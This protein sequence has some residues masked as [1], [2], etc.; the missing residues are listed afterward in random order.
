M[1]PTELLLSKL[2]DA[3]QN[4]NGWIAK[5]PA[6]DDRSPSLSISEGDDGRA[7]VKC[8]AG[9]STDRVVEEMGLKMSDLMSSKTTENEN[10]PKTKSGSS[11]P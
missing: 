7:L 8:H 9:C 10:K 3:K 5:C 6:H 11:K 2:P 1:K 4:S